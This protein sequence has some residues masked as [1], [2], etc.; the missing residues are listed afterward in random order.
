VLVLS[1]AACG[2]KGPPLAP[3]NMA[4]G[5]PAAATARRL[6][7]TVYL[8]LN[9][10]DKSVSGRGAFSVDHLDVYAVTIPP[11]TKVPITR[12]FLKPDYVIA[13]IPIQPPPDPDAAEPE[14]PDPRPR[15][16]DPLTFVEQLT[17]AQLAPTPL[18]VSKQAAAEEKGAK[19]TGSEPL[20]A[21]AAA[22]P[23]ALGPPVLTRYYMVMGVPKK[24]RGNVPSARLEVP[25]LQAPA[26]PRPGTS[27]AD[28]T[29]VTITWQAPP[30]TSDEVSGLLYNV[31]AAPAA[32]VAPPAAD[33]NERLAAPTPLNDKPLP[34]TAFSKPGAEPGK[35]Q[36]FVVRSVAAVGPTFQIESDPSSPICVT[37]KDTF[38]PAAPKGLAAVAS[39]AVVNLIWDAS[40]ETDLA[41]YIV[42]RGDAGDA[43]L[44]PLMAEA[45]KETR[46]TDRTARP[47]VR[48]AY[49][50]VA[51]DKAGNRSA[52]SN[53]VE[54]A[55]R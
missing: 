29:S 34:D 36:C 10:P 8:H 47:G 22:P 2:K 17:D 42:L 12:E 53:R 50:I 7:D 9:V 13:K 43:T 21:A 4:P 23:A 25:L 27:A 40:P 45:I 16:G 33:G 48:Y 11:G 52:P 55:A 32:G 49:Q 19:K 30:T 31:Y 3:L 44:Q 24:G 54:E 6:G 20:P 46:Y 28:E 38:P 26:A 35:Q 15:P 51:V 5:A 37:P 41:G 39:T 18:V 1:S 14:T